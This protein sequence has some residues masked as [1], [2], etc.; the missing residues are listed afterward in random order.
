MMASDWPR[1]LSTG[2]APELSM[3][4]T[5]QDLVVAP[6]ELVLPQEPVAPDAVQERPTL[7]SAET[8]TDP[9]AAALLSVHAAEDPAAPVADARA[10]YRSDER[11]AAN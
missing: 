4:D 1:K 2:A 5:N 7:S 8:L 9:V 6:E 11:S 10:A 3:L